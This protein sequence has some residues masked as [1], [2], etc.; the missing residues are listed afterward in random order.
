MTSARV[1]VYPSCRRMAESEKALGILC[2][3]MA[4][5]TSSPSSAFAEDAPSANPSMSV[6][7]ERPTKAA[8]PMVWTSHPVPSPRT[9]A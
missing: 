3:R 2:A 1:R 7:S 4:R 5:K 6:W 9:C 8:M